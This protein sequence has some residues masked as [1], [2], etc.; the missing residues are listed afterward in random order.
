LLALAP[1]D[2]ATFLVKDNWVRLH[3]GFAAG[4]LL[5]TQAITTVMA[6]LVAGWIAGAGAALAAL[7]G[8]IVVLV[9][10]AYFAAKIYLRPQGSQA[11]DVLGAFYRGE[12]AK[13]LLTAVLFFIGARLFGQHFGA[14]MLTSIACLT[15]NWLV[16]A[17]DRF[18]K[19]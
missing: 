12:L 7:F 10:T 1:L 6:A 16:L 4:A 15:M 17:L 2:E 19:T 11:Q 13:L 18:R 9:P 14:L 5:C 3:A 8:G